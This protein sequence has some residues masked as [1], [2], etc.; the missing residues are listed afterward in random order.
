[1]KILGRSW[2]SWPT[3]VHCPCIFW[4]WRHLPDKPA[5]YSNLRRQ[6][7]IKVSQ[8]VVWTPIVREFNHE[9]DSSPIFYRHKFLYLFF[10]SVKNFL[11]KN[12]YASWMILTSVSSKSVF[13]LLVNCLIL[14]LRALSKRN[15]TSSWFPW[16]CNAWKVGASIWRTANALAK[17]NT[18]GPDPWSEIPSFSTENPSRISLPNLIKKVLKMYFWS[19][20]RAG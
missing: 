11:I 6:P 17:W 9:A 13:F 4:T 14:L 5:Q 16:L 1:M 12:W 2:P 10:E 20:S 8:D 3:R 19:W 7:P 18:F 15:L